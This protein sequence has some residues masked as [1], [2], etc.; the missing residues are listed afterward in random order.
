MTRPRTW[1]LLLAVLLAC[2]TALAQPDDGGKRIW[3]GPPARFGPGTTRNSY[4]SMGINRFDP[5][6]WPS[7][8]EALTQYGFCGKKIGPTGAGNIYASV[9]GPGTAASRPPALP[10]VLILRVPADAAV[11]IG[12][13]ATAQRGE[14]RRFVTPPL[15]GGR[16]V[17]YE[18][19]ARW[20]EGGREVRRRQVIHLAPGNRSTV[21]FLAEEQLGPPRKLGE[22]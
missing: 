21:D 4:P 16:P 5:Y 3:I 9:L 20:R 6:V 1:T 13:Q 2:G 18:V 19:E 22:P 8:R 12:G 14:L 7:L 15:E 17:A 11:V 10:A